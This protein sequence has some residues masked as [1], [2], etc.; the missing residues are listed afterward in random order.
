VTV[1]DSYVDDGDFD[2]WVAAADWVVLPYRRSWSSGVLARAHAFGT[3]AIV[4]GVGGL[5]E[6]AGSGDMVV[7]DDEGLRRAMRRAGM[8]GGEH[9]GTG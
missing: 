9:G 1:V 6:Q 5:R 8:E 7:E 3:P 2:R 4:S